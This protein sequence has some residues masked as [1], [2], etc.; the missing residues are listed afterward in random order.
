M[1]VC[2]HRI[3]KVGR[4][5]GDQDLPMWPNGSDT[6]EKGP[7][8]RGDGILKEANG[9]GCDQIG[10]VLARMPRVRF[11]IPGHAG[12]V[13]NVGPG[14]DQNYRRPRSVDAQHTLEQDM[15]RLTIRAIPALGERVV[16]CGDGV[17]IYELAG[18]VGVVTRLL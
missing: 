11:I 17:G 5:I 13:V 4:V 14:I 10:R 7:I 12:V 3:E 18:I 6:E 16:V 9:F 8:L 1:A 15:I 2:W